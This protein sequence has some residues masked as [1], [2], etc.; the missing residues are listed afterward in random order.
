MKDQKQRSSNKFSASA[1]VEWSRQILVKTGAT[2]AAA[3]ATAR[4][5][6]DAQRRGVDTHGFVM[7][8]L[9]LPM[10]RN[11]AIDGGG[12]PKIIADGPGSAVVDGRNGLG[13]YAAEFAVEL[14]CEKAVSMGAAATVVRRSSHFGAAS[15]YSEMAARKGCV[16]IA[17]SN[18]DPGMAPL[19]ALGP[20]LG[21]NP[22]AIAAPAAEESELLSLDIATS[23]VALGR[24]RAAARRGEAL[25]EGWAMGADGSST[26]DPEAALQGS[27]LPAAGH[28]GFGLALMIDVLAGCLSGSAT[29]PWISA[30]PDGQNHPN[31]GH[32]FVALYIP[33]FAESGVFDRS[34]QELVGA[35]HSAPRREGIPEFQVPGEREHATARERQG[36]IP[37]AD[38]DQELLEQLGFEFGLPFPSRA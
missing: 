34:L 26:R 3:D 24:I 37:L 8:R 4:A 25:P 18:S 10:I 14:A 36:G 2:K 13:P 6:L 30:D 12:S 7:L 11:G 23:V 1:L 38:E 29:S 16:C 21:T 28:K 32:F 5:L 19:G 9:F 33:A 31:V 27:L 20:V 22:L 17:A 35:V 15:V